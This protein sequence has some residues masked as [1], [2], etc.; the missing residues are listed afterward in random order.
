MPRLRIKHRDR[1]EDI[2]EVADKV[3]L[4]RDALET[5]RITDKGVSRQHAEIFKVGE[6]VFI[7]DLNSTNGTFV[8]QKKVLEGELRDGDKIEI[9][10]TVL[11]F[12][13]HIS[14]L[15]KLQSVSRAKPEK[16]LPFLPTHELA[17]M[18]MQALAEPDMIRGPGDARLPR[19]KKGAP[20]AVVPSNRRLDVTSSAF[21]DPDR[22][23]YDSV[24]KGIAERLQRLLSTL[25]MR[26]ALNMPDSRLLV[27]S[28]DG[29]FMPEVEEGLRVRLNFTDPER[30]Q[31]IVRSLAREFRVWALA[32]SESLNCSGMEVDSAGQIFMRCKRL[33]DE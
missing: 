3:T 18:A 32:N 19:H 27:M 15:E 23:D 13:G 2:V 5:I 17:S 28:M 14:E 9:G 29:R 8:N 22:V 30:F 33:E 25:A 24:R 4:G 7:R 10:E 16:S 6:M 21:P 31:T 12:E 1:T 11:I 20:R 26:Q